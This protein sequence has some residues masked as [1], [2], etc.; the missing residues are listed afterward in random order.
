MTS[1]RF[2][3]YVLLDAWL[4]PLADGW[5]FPTHVVE[6]M[7]NYR[8]EFAVLMWREALN[9]SAEMADS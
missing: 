6:P 8:G 1:V 7:R 4:V 5:R 3:R 2:A 9:V